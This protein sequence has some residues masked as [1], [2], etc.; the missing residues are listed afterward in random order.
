MLA[1]H[2]PIL[3]GM[4][5]FLPSSHRV[6]PV[7]VVLALLTVAS[8]PRLAHAQSS[9]DEGVAGTVRHTLTGAVG[10]IMQAQWTPWAHDRG[11]G[12]WSAT[13]RVHSN[14]SVVATVESESD[15]SLSG[16][17]VRMA[18]GRLAPWDG[19]AITVSAPLAPGA[20]TVAV[21]LVPP[22]GAD[23]QVPPAVRLRVVAAPRP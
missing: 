10:P 19:R 13:A 23:T 7:S 21:H 16:W 2:L 8:S 9:Y 18:D 22:V 5:R 6:V 3:I 15:A 4:C 12:E 20:S 14:V 1:R 17:H 11:R